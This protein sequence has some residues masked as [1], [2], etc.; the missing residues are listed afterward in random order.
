MTRQ[1]LG[2]NGQM[3]SLDVLTSSELREA[4]GH[5][6]DT[7]IR[8]WVRG[9]DYVM[10]SGPGNSTSQ[11]T[12][13]VAPEQGYV[14]SLKYV[15]AQLTV[16]GALSV[17]PGDGINTAPMGVATAITQNTFSSGFDAWVTFSSNQG[18]IKDG[19]NITLF[20]GGSVILNWRILALQVPAEMQGKL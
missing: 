13:P 4:M 2:P 10:Y 15:S 18:I 3:G 7:Y 20:A 12:L 11:I 17:Y 9:L 14:W 8:E 19:R 16:A 5:G 1:P 6:I